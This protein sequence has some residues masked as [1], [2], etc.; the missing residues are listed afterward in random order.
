LIVAQVEIWIDKNSIT[1]PVLSL[2]ATQNDSRICT[3][4]TITLGMH[5]RE[6][7]AQNVT[8]ASPSEGFPA[9]IATG[10]EVI[11]SKAHGLGL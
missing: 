3:H 6:V 2:S 11:T 10:Q 9:T 7:N 5:C 1:L 4:A 8:K